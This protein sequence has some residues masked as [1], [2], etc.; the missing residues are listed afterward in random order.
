MKIKIFPILKMLFV[1]C[2][3]TILIIL[4]NSSINSIPRL[5]SI[6]ASSSWILAILVHIPQFL[7]PFI[8]IVYLSK[9]RIEQYG[10][11]LEESPPIFTR[12]RM[13][14][15]GVAFGLLLSLK[16]I[17]QI[18]IDKT[19]D[20]PQPITPLN[21]LGS[22]IFQWVVVGLCE[23]TMFRG[24]IQ[25]YLMENLHG[26]VKIVKHDLHV[27]TVI[28]AVIWGAF[29]FINI[30]VMPWDST[31]LTVVLTTITGLLMGYAYQETRSL[32]IT[33]IIH[34]TLFGIPL[35]IGYVIYFLFNI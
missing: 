5:T 18:I 4:I 27:G 34:N 7:I 12:N 23:E 10:F 14:K 33:I 16:Y 30:L 24:L 15:I 6:V 2:V 35:L 21:I 19:I 1:T 32:S 8:L 9:G 11:N 25:T 20:I 26:Y 13:L 28:G 22:L 17:P 31:I 29:H 3:V